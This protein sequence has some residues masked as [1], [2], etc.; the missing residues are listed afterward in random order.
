MYQIEMVENTT[1]R[2]A[3]TI[4]LLMVNIVSAQTGISG[5]APVTLDPAGLDCAGTCPAV[6]VFVDVTGLTGTGGDAGL[7]AFVLSFD[8]DRSETF[9]F[10]QTGHAP[11]MGWFFTHTDPGTVALSNTV[12]IVGATGDDTAPNDLY[13][14]ATL[15][16]CGTPGDVTLTFDPNTSSLGSRVIAGDGPGPI[17]ISAPAPFVLSIADEITLDFI[18]GCASWLQIFADYDL[19]APTGP[20][21]ILDL[22]KLAACSN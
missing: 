5:S 11:E 18:E 15:V 19:V 21:D 7:N 8:L 4:I 17:S 20:I 9:T 10:S 3:I 13:H 12:T 16:F 14:V 6:D 1:S 2:V 22:V